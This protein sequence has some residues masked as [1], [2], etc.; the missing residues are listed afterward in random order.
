M[1]LTLKV[2]GLKFCNAMLFPVVLAACFFVPIDCDPSRDPELDK[3][4][5]YDPRGREM[6]LST[7]KTILPVSRS[8]WVKPSEVGRE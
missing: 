5:F 8:D 1:F 2:I 3:P 6:D 7:A 4:L